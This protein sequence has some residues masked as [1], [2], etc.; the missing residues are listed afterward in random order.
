V[1]LSVLSIDRLA[2]AAITPAAHAPHFIFSA[3]PGA[4]LSTRWERCV[5]HR[6]PDDPP[7]MRRAGCRATVGL[8][9]SAKSACAKSRSSAGVRPPQAA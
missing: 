5:A 2:Q 8:V 4:L 7:G 9:A 1:L 3:A 6:E